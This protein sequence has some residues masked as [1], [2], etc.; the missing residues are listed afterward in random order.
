MEI[1]AMRSREEK[2]CMMVIRMLFVALFVFT[3]VNVLSEK[4]PDW[5][6][7]YEASWSKQFLQ[8]N[9]KGMSY[10]AMVNEVGL[11]ARTMPVP[12]QSGHVVY[13]FKP[14]SKLGWIGRY[15]CRWRGEPIA[16]VVFENDH[17]SHAI[18]IPPER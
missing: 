16:G 15:I 14:Y 6:N 17:Y 1:N 5:L 12:S 13:L 2:R 9:L 3:A 8:E 10:A 18:L 11:P 4:M 7:S